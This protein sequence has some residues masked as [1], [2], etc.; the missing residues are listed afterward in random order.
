MR[1]QPLAVIGAFVF[2]LFVGATAVVSAQAPRTPQ[3]QIRT[4]EA[5]TEG[6]A[7]RIVGRRG[8]RVV[9]TLVAKV[10]GEWVEVQ[11]APQDS[12]ARTR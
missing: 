1:I 12:F 4:Q 7:V 5:V 11:L 3:L 8:G 6:V 9:G 10:D 2:G